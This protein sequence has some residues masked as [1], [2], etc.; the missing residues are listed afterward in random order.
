MIKFW[1]I[2]GDFHKERA[3]RIG[4]SQV[5]AIIPNP[6][7]PTESLAG[8]GNTALTV[9]QEKRGE[10]KREPAGLAAEMGHFLE[11]KAL[12]L[13]I[14]RFSG[15]NVGR[16]FL[17]DKTTYEMNLAEN[18]ECDIKEFTNTPYHHNTQYYIDGMIAHPDCVYMGDDSLSDLPKKERVK[19]V[20]GISV[21]LSKPFLIEAK[22]ARLFSAKRPE[23]SLVKG[24]DTKLT[25]WQGIPLKHYM[26]IQYQLALFEVDV[27]Y[28]ALISDTS[29]FHIWRIDADKKIQGKII[30]TVGLLLR[31]IENGIMPRELAMNADDIA[32]MYPE[33]KGDFIMLNGEKLE[34]VKT[35]CLE[36][37][38][39]DQQEKNWKAK[40]K[41]ATDALSVYL[42]DF[43]EIRDGSNCMAKWQIRGGSEKITK[44]I[45][46][47]KD[48]FID[49]LKKNDKVAY[50]YLLKRE[51]IKTGKDSRFVKVKFKGE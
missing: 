2:S 13:F 39:A 12:E 20:D 23:G 24:Y 17:W 15:V 19:V 3:T 8:F 43:S 50:R 6:E 48:S 28:L 31:H 32:I 27:C 22:S 51:Y 34:A 30:D 44:P 18:T 4:A 16:D 7:N 33:L 37:K 49:Y 42:K 25:S 11:N 38:K 45:E 9:Y 14:R 5:P 1:Y 35:A 26:Q 40:K 21:D 46:A 41:D 47:G 10:R 36:Y 29:D